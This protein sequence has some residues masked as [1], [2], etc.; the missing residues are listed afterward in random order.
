MTSTTLHEIT[1][2]KRNGKTQRFD[3]Q[4]ITDRLTRLI[5]LP[6][7][8]ILNCNA[9]IVVNK[10]KQKINK[11]NITTSEI[12]ELAAKQ[13]YDFITVHPDY[14]I[15]AARIKVANLHKNTDDCFSSFIDKAVNNTNILKK[16]NPHTPL[17]NSKLNKFVKNN[18]GRINS[19]IKEDRDFEFDWLGINTL[20]DRYLLKKSGNED[21][22]LIRPQ[23]FI[24]ERPQYL[25][26]RI[27][28]TLSLNQNWIDD[29]KLEIFN[30]IESIYNLLSLGLISL[31]TPTMKNAGTLNEQLLS[32]FLLRVDDNTESIMDVGRMLALISKG[33]GGTG[34]SMN[35]RPNGS[36]VKKTNGRSGG[37]KPFLKIYEK[38][39]EAFDQGGNRPGSG[40][41][42][43]R[44]W[45]AEF[46][47]W[48]RLRRPHEPTEFSI[49]KLFY[50]CWVDDYFMECVEKDLDWYYIS[51][52]EHPELVELYGDE[53]TKQYIS[54]CQSIKE[55]PIKNKYGSTTARKVWESILTTII[56]T[57]MPY[58]LNADRVNEL[59]NQKNIGLI[60]NSNL[61]AEICEVAT[62]E[63][64]ACCC[65]GTLAV[66]KFLKL[67]PQY[68]NTEPDISEQVSSS[69]ESSSSSHDD[70][71]DFETTNINDMEFGV[72]I[73]TVNEII[74]NKYS[75]DWNL[76]KSAAK[77]LTWIL[78]KVIDINEYPVEQAKLANMEQRPLGIGI[79][80]M[81]DA[82]AMMKIVWGSPE[83]RK[84]CSQVAEV[85][86]YSC[87]EAS[88]EM[89]KKSKTPYPYF[90]ANAKFPTI[91]NSLLANGIFQW[92]QWHSTPSGKKLELNPVIP[93][94]N[95]NLNWDQLR[96]NVVDH[97]VCNS[98]FNAYP[99]T[100]T[101]SNIQ[102]NIES[103]EPFKNNTYLR[104][105]ISGSF[106]IVNKYL[107][108]DLMSL[109]LWNK[110]IY[111]QMI[112]DD[113]S[114]QKIK[115]IPSSIRE[116]YKTAWEIDP[117]IMAELSACYAPWVD[118]TLSDNIF[119]P[120][121]SDGKL[122]T[123]TLLHRR[124]L[125]LKTMM[126][127]LKQTNT[128]GR[129]KF[130]NDSIKINEPIEQPNMCLINNPDCEACQ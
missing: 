115:S 64:V 5:I 99:P 88:C 51:K 32:C 6:N 4:K 8:P 7:L 122:L 76:F 57:G 78:N 121:A 119:I 98:L 109:N 95:L 110:K 31:A 30:R 65:L 17:I 12:D 80:G 58:L 85:L 45:E 127:Y 20:I 128:T 71:D 111:K 129:R 62:P 104:K 124:R 86:H 96:K 46:P 40:T 11:N 14:G 59:S 43:K 21:E 55:D 10:T 37:Q 25:W 23:D 1:I 52:Y 90:K 19:L 36:E 60:H 73:K 15:L 47:E 3:E 68:I 2:I 82:F 106:I 113:G 125:G 50:A 29:N 126:Y 69:E 56:E 53:F 34:W 66:N 33:A 105:T 120:K 72:A 103:F 112:E 123:Q 91:D 39:L 97:G 89:A 84:F 54:I 18:K 92:Q 75:M 116:L 44:I 16:D 87:I 13:A 100:A 77:E 24:I 22:K 107:I 42:Y 108:E 67:L 101:S 81:A 9:A 130:A 63:R 41:D 102:G 70:D 118:Q 74:V 94:P 28:C 35:V 117:I 83:S 79:Q 61:C 27:A 93:D 26:M 48:I 49:R 38:I 114:I